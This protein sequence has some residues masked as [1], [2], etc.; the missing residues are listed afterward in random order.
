M[1]DSTNN[2]IQITYHIGKIC[3]SHCIEVSD[4]SQKIAIVAIVNSYFWLQSKNSYCWTQPWRQ[5]ENLDFSEDVI[6]F[7]SQ[8]RRSPIDGA[9]ATSLGGAWLRAWIC[10]QPEPRSSTRLPVAWTYCL[11][12][13]KQ[14]QRCL[15]SSLLV[16]TK[17][18]LSRYTSKSLQKTALERIESC[19]ET[20]R[21]PCGTG[22]GGPAGT[23]CATLDHLLWCPCKTFKHS[24]IRWRLRVEAICLLILRVRR[25]SKH[26]FFLCGRDASGCVKLCVSWKH[27][28]D[29]PVAY[30]R[31]SVAC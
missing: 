10:E 2:F 8:G 26:L 22:S 12:E 9:V 19:M 6:Q 21:A 31:N 23:A 28:N 27:N 30:L 17:A 3:Y 15:F 1:S 11:W 24:L 25:W 18:S 14:T 13:C 16:W 20:E 4:F 5:F 7:C 29:V